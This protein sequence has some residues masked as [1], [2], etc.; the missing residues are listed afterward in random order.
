VTPDNI[1]LWKKMAKLTVNFVI[2]IVMSVSERKKI[3]VLIVFLI[4][5]YIKESVGIV[6]Y[7]QIFIWIQVNAKKN[8][9]K[10]IN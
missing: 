9:G 3:N 7:T 4:K 1:F 5:F 2:K 8:A 10:A 6:I